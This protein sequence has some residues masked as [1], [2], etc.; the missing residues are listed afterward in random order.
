MRSELSG[1]AWFPRA[2]GNGLD[3]GAGI[4][5]QATPWLAFHARVDLRRYFFAMNPE[6]GDMWIAGGATDQYFG[7]A[8]GASISPR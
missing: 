1:N 5:L 6:P 2:T 3:A 8:I 4:T 7:G